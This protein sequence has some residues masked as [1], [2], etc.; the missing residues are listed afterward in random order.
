MDAP[1]IEVIAMSLHAHVFLQLSH[2]GDLG[3][4]CVIV[5]VAAIL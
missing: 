2:A 1:A 4:N 5:A 3:Q